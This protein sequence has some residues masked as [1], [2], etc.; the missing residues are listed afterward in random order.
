MTILSVLQTT[1]SLMHLAAGS[2]RVDV[3]QYLLSKG[4]TLDHLSVVRFC[5][6][7]TSSSI[8]LSLNSLYF[9]TDTPL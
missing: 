1:Y 9:S 4:C 7:M 8:D 3:L 5:H 6:S 2:G